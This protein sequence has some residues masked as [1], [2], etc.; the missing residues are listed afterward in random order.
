M[1]WL[2]PSPHNDG[3]KLH[4]RSEFV[5]SQFDDDE[6]GLFVQSEQIDASSALVPFG[7]LFDSD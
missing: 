7:K 1:S 4:V 6:V 3:L 2:K 5:P